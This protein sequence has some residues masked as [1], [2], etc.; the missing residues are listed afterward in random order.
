[1]GRFRIPQKPGSPYITPEGHRLLRNELDFLWRIKRPEVTRIVSAAAAQGDRSEN[2]DYIYGKKQLAEIDR[3][4][5]YLKRRLDNLIIVDQK[6]DNTKQVFFGA[7]VK[8]INKQKQTMTYRL[9]GCDEIDIA[10]ENISIDAPLAKALL[11]KTIDDEI[12]V[13]LPKGISCFQIV[14]VQYEKFL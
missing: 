12:T 5:R 2:A 8:L 4:V 11:K 6:P 3:R 1:M 7:W 13:S 9:V 10:E 14:E